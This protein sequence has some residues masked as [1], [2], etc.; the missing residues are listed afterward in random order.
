M[1]PLLA[2][3]RD[4]LADLCRRF[5]VRRLD[6]FGSAVRP[7]DFDVSRSDVDFLVELGSDADDLGTFID[8]KEALEALLGRPV[9]LV[10]RQAVEAS[11]NPIRRRRILDEAEPL[12]DDIFRGS[13]AA[14]SLKLG[15]GAEGQ[16]DGAIFRGSNAAASLKRPR[17][18]SLPGPSA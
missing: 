10:E 13:N 4:A 5:R 3:Q 1:H 7:G 8:F 15:I 17:P 11:R 16:G 2:D 12:Y 18:A 14:A 6:A 9:D